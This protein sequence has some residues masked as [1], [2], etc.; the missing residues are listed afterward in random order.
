MDKFI[1]PTEIYDFENNNYQIYNS[2]Y[3][4][5]VPNIK[6]F[7]SSP[8]NKKIKYMSNPRNNKAI[9]KKVLN[10]NYPN[11]NIPNYTFENCESHPNLI[12]YKNKKA[13]TN[14]R[15]IE[16][17]KVVHISPKSKNIFNKIK[18]EIKMIQLQLTSDI[19]KNKIQLLHN[20]GNE[21]DE[22]NYN[23]VNI[24]YKD[25]YS[26]NYNNNTLRK[27]QIN[28]NKAKKRYVLNNKNN[29]YSIPNKIQIRPNNITNANS[30][31]NIYYI[32][33]NFRIN[34]IQNNENKHFQ[35]PKTNII[36]TASDNYMPYSIKQNKVINIPHNMKKY[37]STSPNY[38][39][40]KSAINENNNIKFN[41]NNIS[42]KRFGGIILNKNIN[43]NMNNNKKINIIKKPNKSYKINNQLPKGYFDDYLISNKINQNVN[44]KN[45]EIIHRNNMSDNNY[46]IRNNIR[47]VDIQNK[48]KNNNIV[49]KESKSTNEFK[50][51]NYNSFFINNARRRKNNILQTENKIIDFSYLASSNIK[52]M[53][54]INKNKVINTINFSF[55]PTKIVFNANKNNEQNKINE[56]NK[57]KDN[58]Q[59]NNKNLTS[60]IDPCELEEKSIILDNN[61]PGEKIIIKKPKKLIFDDTKIIVKYNQGDYIR[62]HDSLYK[63]K[64]NNEKNKTN[65]EN[66]GD[67]IS[68]K[69]ISTTKLCD[70]LK[71]K[72]KNLKSNLDKNNKIHNEYNPNEALKKLNELIFDDS[73]TKP[74]K[75]NA[76][77][78]IPKDIKITI[79]NNNNQNDIIKKNINFI[80]NLEE[81]NK[82]GINYRSL[83]LSKREINLLNKKQKN[84]GFKFKNNS[85]NLFPDK[86]RL[87]SLPNN[88][89][90]SEL[91]KINKNRIV[92]YFEKEKIK[93]DDNDNN[94]KLNKS[95][96]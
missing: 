33:N 76:D 28:N 45:R 70:K 66:K 31:K 47:K 75:E 54:S 39:F 42:P 14:N 9:N 12:F 90:D 41:N 59:S 94:D 71:K 43:N 3:R 88:M 95:F 24:N 53:N 13:Y 86:T 49:I 48:N 7:I 21:E 5:Q 56:E 79:T 77:N 46:I 51:E 85:Q 38:F 6:N 23:N 68:H 4:I 27:N 96:S 19:L 63:I 2:Q 81:C 44:R 62:N 89:D 60:L 15:N 22:H 92:N 11:K 78:K 61:T 18:K 29:Y 82:K 93:E 25:Y 67:K 64:I 30:L 50:I 1:F 8:K 73:P 32:N 58:T 84:L 26:Q 40:S 36:N 35:I 16:I 74:K 34:S 91:I 52:S 65:E 10:P 57:N 87:K 17:N 80:K 55:N 37:V 72:N 83:T 69:F 20:L